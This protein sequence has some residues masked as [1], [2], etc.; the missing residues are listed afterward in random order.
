MNT[1]N[2]NTLPD[3]KGYKVTTDTVDELTGQNAIIDTSNIDI[4]ND[5]KYM[6]KLK[7]LCDSVRS[8]YDQIFI[9]IPVSKWYREGNDKLE[10]SKTP[11]GNICRYI[12]KTPTGFKK[13]FSG[14]AFIF[15]N[16]ANENFAL[17]ADDYKSSEY[18]TFINL[19]N[20]LI[21]NHKTNYLTGSDD[22]KNPV[23]DVADD[24]KDKKEEIESKKQ[25][26]VDAISTA[27][28]ESETEEEAWDKINDDEYIKQLIVDLDQED[29]GKPKFNNARTSRMISVNDEFMNKK[30]NGKSVK[31]IIDTMDNAEKIPPEHLKVSSINKEWET[32]RFT[33]FEKIYDV[34]A[35]ILAILESFSKKSYP[36]VV[37]DVKVE[38]TST[39]MDYV[40]TYTVSMEDG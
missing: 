25:D 15:Y 12:K 39:N 27:A 3:K 36:S 2:E 38:D 24:K 31:E 21:S 30:F 37:L 11:V 13:E 29:D 9:Y 18:N 32:V 4:N 28:E 33:N 6:S 10:V 16:D 7:E 8:K 23:K 19:L 40:D 34:N 22:K 20:V 17:I 26:L 14:V 1:I 5:D 35:D